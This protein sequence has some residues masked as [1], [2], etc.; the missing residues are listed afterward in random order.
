[1]KNLKDPNKT[2]DICRENGCYLGLFPHTTDEFHYRWVS[3]IIRNETG[4]EIKKPKKK[5]KK[6]LCE[7]AHALG[8]P[9]LR[10]PRS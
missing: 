1:M 7:A 5:G 8:E 4:E 3:D 2:L 10:R 6:A 9:V